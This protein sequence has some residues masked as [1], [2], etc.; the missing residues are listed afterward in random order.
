[1]MDFDLTDKVAIVTGGSRGLGKAICKSLASEGANVVI[2]Y[3]KDQEK[4]KKTAE[5]IKNEYN[6]KTICVKGDITIEEDVKRIFQEAFKE[7][8]RIDILVNNSGICP[9][10]MVKDMTLKEWKDVIETNL[11]GTFLTCREMVNFLLTQK[12]KGKIVNIASQSAFNGSKSGKSHYSASKGG[13]VTFTLSLAKEVAPYG[14]RV[15]AVAPGMMYTDMTSSALD[16]NLEKYLKEIPV[17]RIA[18]VDEVARVV[19][20]LS[21]DVSSYIS[22]AT[23][24]VSGG[25]VGR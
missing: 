5:E 15:N 3:R 25:I 21:S 17:G 1:M 12:E 24:D 6:V 11:T 22:G 4:A 14:I 8:S 9:V 13:V 23:L 2:N 18:E 20:F 10:S 16:R 7:F 19:A